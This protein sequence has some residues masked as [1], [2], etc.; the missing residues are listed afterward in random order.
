[1][2]YQ[3]VT[4]SY[5]LF[6]LKS[7]Q[8]S[9]GDEKFSFRLLQLLCLLCQLLCLLL[10]CQRESFDNSCELVHSSSRFLVFRSNSFKRLSFFCLESCKLREILQQSGLLVYDVIK[11]STDLG[12]CVSQS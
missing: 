3:E 10:T 6:V 4:A 9:F 5:Q 8:F 11:P 2:V 12:S 7:C 1:M